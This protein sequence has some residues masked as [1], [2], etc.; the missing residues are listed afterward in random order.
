MRFIK[1]EFFI[2]FKQKQKQN[3][4]T[5][6]KA[7][8]KR[9]MHSS[10]KLLITARPFCLQESVYITRNRSSTSVYDI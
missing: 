7:K 3:K 8:L 6:K 5:K 9:P 1:R 10:M 2:S 4:K